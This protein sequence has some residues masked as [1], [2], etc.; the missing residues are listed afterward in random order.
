MMQIQP[1]PGCEDPHEAS[2]LL[3]YIDT[4]NIDELDPSLQ[5][6]HHISVEA[7]ILMKVSLKG[8]EETHTSNE[9]MHLKVLVRGDEE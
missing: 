5:G 4:Q 6:G 7:D 8:K 1:V 2:K 9:M 3:T